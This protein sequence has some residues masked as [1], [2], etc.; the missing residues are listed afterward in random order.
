MEDWAE[1]RRLSRSEGLSGRQIA[2]QLRVS[3]NT[4]AAALM[5][6][7]PPSY[8]RDPRG[9][10]LDPYEPPIRD[11]LRQFP[12]M[13]ATVIAERIGWTR[14]SSLLRERVAEL[15]PLY[16]GVDPADRT[17]YVA[18]ELAQCDLW[19]PPVRVPLGRG[20]FGSPP[21]LVMACG[22]SRTIAAVMLPSRRM[23][24]LL[25]GMWQL[26]SG[27]GACP[28]ALVWD[29][30]PGIGHHRR[31]AAGAAAFAGTLG[32]RFLQTKPRDPE[33]KGIVER[34]NQFLETSF[35]PGRTFTSAHDF[36]TQ[37]SAWLVK[38]NHRKVRRI[39]A[40]PVDLFD[41]DLASMVT[42]PPI[43]PSVGIRETVRLPRDYYVRLDA[44]DYSVHSSVIGRKVE[45]HATLDQVLVYCQSRLVAQHRRCW[46]KHATITDPAHRQAAAI[47]RSNYAAQAQKQSGLEAAA[48]RFQIRALPD[49]DQLFADPPLE[50]EQLGVPVVDFKAVS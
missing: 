44:A 40:R 39:G 28:K 36:N 49:Y 31:S 3:R 17:E 26:I 10:I 47:A 2:E 9:S 1:I 45:V 42:L 19:F 20:Q 29:N 6:T 48:A 8:E 22:F 41:R 30:E 5:A 34:A 15:R 13:P 43:A 14:S 27:W 32:M 11:L 23:G 12:S 33:A 18:G 7:G 38:A 37:L 50:A 25:S 21:V 4:V 24:D 46:A 35:L 16:R